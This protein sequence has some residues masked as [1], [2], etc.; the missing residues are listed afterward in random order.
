MKKY[1]TKGFL[2]ISSIS[3]L[4]LISGYSGHSLGGGV[5][6]T[7]AAV[8]DALWKI[9]IRTE[10]MLVLYEE[11]KQM[12]KTTKEIADGIQEELAIMND[13]KNKLKHKEKKEDEIEEVLSEWMKPKKRKVFRVFLEAHQPGWQISLEKEAKEHGKTKEEI[14][15]IVNKKLDDFDVEFIKTFYE[16]EDKKIEEVM[17]IGKFWQEEGE[18][19]LNTIKERSMAK[20][21]KIRQAVQAEEK[22]QKGGRAWIFQKMKMIEKMIDKA[23]YSECSNK[24]TKASNIKLKNNYSSENASKVLRFIIG[25]SEKEVPGKTEWTDVECALLLMEER[26][27]KTEAEEKSGLPTKLEEMIKRERKESGWKKRKAAFR[28][29]EEK[30]E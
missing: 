28:N 9:G 18:I 19:A 6:S 17:E 23:K 26:M 22:A 24:D 1:S 10:T 30:K 7:I 12:G 4:L 27:G 14:T 20:I 8:G 2:R 3:L 11:Q 21:E 15:E 29:E 16:E 25:V 13:I 5:I